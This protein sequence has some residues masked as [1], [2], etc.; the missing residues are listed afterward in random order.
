MRNE[1]LTCDAY[2][3]NP[4]LR[5]QIEQQ[6]RRERAAAVDACL[7]AAVASVRKLLQRA[8]ATGAARP[9]PL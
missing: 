7:A 1:H 5:K 3:N 8:L 2:L 4:E 6:A 9:A